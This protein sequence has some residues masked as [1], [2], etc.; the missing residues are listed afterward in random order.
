[1]IDKIH[2][3]KTKAG[4]IETL[5]G[6]FDTSTGTIA[7]RAKFPNPQHILKHGSSGKIRLSNNIE[8]ALL[9][10]Q[11][12]TFEIQDKFLHL[13]KWNSLLFP[14][15]SDVEISNLVYSIQ[16][17]THLLRANGIKLQGSVPEMVHSL[18]PGRAATGNAGSFSLGRRSA[19]LP[20]TTRPYLKNKARLK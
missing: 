14:F 5:E 18:V 4:K 6:E 7:F 11:K 8:N 3:L 10:P 12:A 17:C 16:A 19:C 9:I 2:L 13:E 1:M 20:R 15:K